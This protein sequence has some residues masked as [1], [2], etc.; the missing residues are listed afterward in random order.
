VFCTID[1]IG[2]ASVV[3]VDDEAATELDSLALLVLVV[4]LADELFVLSP[5]D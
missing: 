4:L 3:L 5:D 2:V 1:S